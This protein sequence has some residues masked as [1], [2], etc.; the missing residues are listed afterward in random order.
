VAEEFTRNFTV[1]GDL[2]A[3][4][5]VVRDGEP[6]VDLW[7]GIADRASARPWSA[8]TLQIL[9][10]GTKGLV[11]T[12]LLLLMERGQ[13]ALESPVARYW[14]E[15]AAAGKSGV[16]VRDLVSHSAGLP[17]LDVPVT[18]QEATDARR[19][20]A[21]LARQ[22]R[23]TD[24]RA[25]RTY[26][27]V[28][29]GWLCGEL[30]RRVDG[31][32]IG[33]FFA[34]EIARPLDLE[35]W[36]GLPAECEPR[37]SAVELAPAWTS[38]ADER[39]ALDPLRR[40]VA[41]PSRYQPESFPWNEREW[42]AAE[43]PSSNGIGTARSVARFYA[44]LGQVLSPATVRL[45]TTVLS[46]RHDPLLERLTSFGV[47]FQLQTD[48][49]ALGPVPDAFGHGGAGGSVHGRWPRQRIGFSY[50][51]NLLRDDP[52]DMRAAALLTALYNCV[53]REGAA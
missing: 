15:F 23:S 34:E 41:N 18:W 28:T 42:H 43:V 9:F 17:G 20:A 31:R 4:F 37:V 38:V 19:M 53:E 51:M 16:L 26:H 22:P 6:L 3:S 2:G 40:A 12:C 35:L 25:T 39:L 11:A 5:A 29:F 21:L 8:D 32:G 1:R 13:L 47:G 7:G 33:Q 45:G 50:A 24:P 27:A 49:L 46:R 30:V 44:S 36:I 48:A 52:G 10:S 14:P